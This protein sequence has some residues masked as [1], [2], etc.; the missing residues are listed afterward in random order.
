[1]L[2]LYKQQYETAVHT[3]NTYIKWVK[4]ITN[5]LIN[6]QS[7]RGNLSSEKNTHKK[8]LSTIKKILQLQ[9]WNFK[10]KYVKLSTFAAVSQRHLK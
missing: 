10:F 7:S 6:H 5:L 1:M 4:I 2:K 3:T 8:I 9:I